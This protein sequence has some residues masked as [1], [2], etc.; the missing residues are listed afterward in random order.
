MDFVVVR[1]HPNLLTYV[2]GLQRKNATAL[3]FYPRVTFEREQEAGR[4][5]LGILNG[6]P[7]G[8]LWHGAFGG[9][10]SWPPSLYPIRC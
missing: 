3:S 10:V 6:E 8:Y 4:I 5:L 9:V 1:S 2:D 7:C